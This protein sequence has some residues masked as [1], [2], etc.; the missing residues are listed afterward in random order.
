VRLLFCYLASNFD[1]LNQ[2][3]ELE[4][5]GVLLNMI[6]SYPP[7]QPWQMNSLAGLHR[8]AFCCLIV[9]LRSLHANSFLDAILLRLIV[10]ASF[11]DVVGRDVLLT[12]CAD[13]FSNVDE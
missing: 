4:S 2:S 8:S 11:A 3:Q 10:L 12:N 6:V 13:K 7:L 1:T 5:G 9:Y